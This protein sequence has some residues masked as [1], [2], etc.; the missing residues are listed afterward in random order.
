M[1]HGLI[2]TSGFL[3]LGTLTLWTRAAQAQSTAVGPYYATPS[4]AQTFACTTPATCPR[5][6]VLSNFNSGAVLDRETGLVWERAPNTSQF[7]YFDAQVHWRA[8]LDGLLIGEPSARHSD[9][10][11]RVRCR[12]STALEEFRDI[13]G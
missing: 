12:L 5:F 7:S 2:Y 6:V 1:R 10:L 8:C 13:G 9:H 4:W 3:V 11:E